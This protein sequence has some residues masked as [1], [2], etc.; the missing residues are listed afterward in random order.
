MNSKNQ[1]SWWITLMQMKIPQ[2]YTFCCLFDLPQNGA[3][4]MI[5][6]CRLVACISLWQTLTTLLSWCLIIHQL[7]VNQFSAVP[8]V[9]FCFWSPAAITSCLL[10]SGNEFSEDRF[11]WMY[12]LL[13]HGA[14]SSLPC[15][16]L[17][18]VY[19]GNLLKLAPK[20]KHQKNSQ[21]LYAWPAFCI[22]YY[23]LY[24]ACWLN[25]HLVCYYFLTHL[26]SMFSFSEKGFFK[27]TVYATTF[28][29]NMPAKRWKIAA[30]P[31]Y[32]T[33]AFCL[34]Q[35]SPSSNSVKFSVLLQCLDIFTQLAADRILNKK[36]IPMKLP[37]FPNRAANGWTLGCCFLL[38]DVL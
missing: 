38:L 10:N 33:P 36:Q 31:H 32:H 13:G 17:P 4:L 26:H 25:H 7:L 18:G 28:V 35:V 8:R 37:I 14:F 12:V 16:C 34:L 22:I 11:G 1:L 24:M 2:T 9:P 21:A 20:P 27:H 6:P 5:D 23:I 15:S 19:H 3:H 29:T 30:N